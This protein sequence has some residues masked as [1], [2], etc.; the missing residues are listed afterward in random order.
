MDLSISEEKVEKGIVFILSG[1]IDT[2]TVPILERALTK[3][4]GS[5]FLDFSDIDYLSSAGIRLLISF[6]K[7][8][9][10]SG[11]RLVLFSLDENVLEVIKMTG[12][13]SLFNI[14][15]TKQEAMASG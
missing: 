2:I 3:T 1:R 7:R 10:S 15:N 9:K 4:N 11:G 6:T 13:L 14:Y 12:L 5:V 8:L